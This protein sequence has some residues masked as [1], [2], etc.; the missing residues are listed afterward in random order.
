MIKMDERAILKYLIL[1]QIKGFGPIRQNRILD[2]CG[3]IEQCFQDEEALIQMVYAKHGMRLG[4]CGRY[5]E[6]D[7]QVQMDTKL[8]HSFVSQ[9]NNPDLFE[10]VKRIM[11]KLYENGIRA[12][13]REDPSY[14]KRFS[15]LRDMPVL[16][17]V[18]GHLRI[19]HF[20]SSVG[21]VGARRC[22][23]EGR[24]KAVEITKQAAGSGR[25][26]VSGMAKGI[27][28]YAHTAALKENGYTVAVLG[29][30]PD[31]CYPIEHRMLYDEII[32]QS[33]IVSE[34][35]PGTPPGRYAFPRRNRMIAALSDELIVIEAGR[36]SGTNTT[37][38]FC[39]EY[40]RN[41][42]SI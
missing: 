14:P 29:C 6:D 10:H 42:H 36:N 22:S 13:C 1:T 24:D 4:N 18:K 5:P 23:R 8:L 20:D 37:A 17:Y 33:C 3:G 39:R 35:P 41:V 12:I 9:R 25:A 34:Y 31:I 11:G 30:G 27:D 26:V 2:L 38:A 7:R 21:I 16:I 19:N 28:S 40:G 32:R 15:G